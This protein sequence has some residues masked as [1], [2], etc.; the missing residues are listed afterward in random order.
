MA[1][2]HD[3]LQ[4][5]QGVMLALETETAVRLLKLGVREVAR[6]D[7]TN[8][9][10]QAALLLKA[11]GFERLLKV[12]LCLGSAAA[13]EGM[14]NVRGYS[15]KLRDLLDAVIERAVAQGYREMPNGRKD[16]AFIDGDERLRE[17]IDVLADFADKGRYR[18]LDT[19]LQPNQDH[20]DLPRHRFD[21][22]LMRIAQQDPHWLRRVQED[23]E[24]VL[25]E[26]HDGVIELTQRLA[27]A[28]CRLFPAGILG[29]RATTLYPYVC[30]YVTI[31]DER[32]AVPLE[33]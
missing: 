16:L 30:D 29:E 13:G 17:M 14:V 10:V 26:S 15:H 31:S 12:A 8:D 2:I 22:L 20:Q 33:G 32:L 18:E 4:P 5:V 24:Q 19:A 28:L 1:Q 21:Q 25:R 23:N 3:G 6:L 7:G 9:F 11:Q 27:R